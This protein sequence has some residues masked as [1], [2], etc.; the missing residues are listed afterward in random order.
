MVVARMAWLKLSPEAQR[1]ASDIL[2]KHPHFA[3]YL[4]ADKPADISVE[5]W[6]F[7]R[8]SYWPDWVRS[9]HSDEYNK[10]TWHYL[11]VAFVPK[12]AR[13]DDAAFALND[14]NI[15][16]QIEAC[17]TTLRSGSDADKAIYLCWLLH[18]VGD[19]HQ[20]LHCASLQSELFPAGDRG[21]NLSMVRVE[22]GMPVR[23]HALWDDLLG[24]A[25]TLPEIE[26]CV[27]S[28]AIES[29]DIEQAPNWQER[30]FI[31]QWATESFE[32]AREHAYLD[33]Q[34]KPAHA[35]TNPGPEAVPSLS[36]EYISSAQRV[37]RAAVVR[38]A[39]RIVEQLEKL[40]R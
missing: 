27:R 18:L 35:E 22:H 38:A 6:A 26:E 37:A 19:I 4:A 24:E 23:L 31:Q 25:A 34:L 7:M 21:G 36:R 30:I 3:E 17:L 1:K 40:S 9:N 15:V 16:T 2:R 33:G 14:P 13:V 20:P 11:S 12:N 8:A 28:L 39:N 5:E 29:G 10:P 32:L